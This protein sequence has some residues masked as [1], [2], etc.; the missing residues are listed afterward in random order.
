MLCGASVKLTGPAHAE[1]GAGIQRMKIETLVATIDQTDH[2]LVEKMNIQT[3]ALIGNQCGRSSEEVFEFR[4]NRVVYLNSA[5]RGVGKN[6]NLLM[7]H[8]AA[9][10]CI[11]ADDDMQ[12]L[13]GYPQT[14]KQAF[15][16]CPQADILIFN[17]VEK[18][19]KRPFTKA[20]T[21]IRTYN[22]AKYGAARIAFRR[23]PVLASGIRFSLSFGGGTKHGSGEDTIFLRDC[24]K[25]GL[26]IYAVPY[27]LAEIDQT[28]A[29]TW[30]EGYSE[31]F[32]RDKGALY[33]C[34][35][36]ALWPLYSAR[37]LVRHRKKPGNAM[38]LMRAMKFMIEGGNAYKAET[39]A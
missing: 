16:E 4:G 36:P 25:K 17:L 32:F 1:F 10:I 28:A 15:Q 7:Q 13:Q 31:K 11:F 19:Q 23:R 18:Q 9:D 29:S 37:Y 5:E 34:L 27:A 35:H 21:R 3:E 39:E 24:L 26:K 6:R 22:Y 14:A 20:I 30:F 33:S 2:S 8:A 12:F 38:P